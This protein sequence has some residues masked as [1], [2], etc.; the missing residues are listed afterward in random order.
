MPG[1]DL[2]R[3]RCD[4]DVTVNR[5]AGQV[6]VDLA[7][8]EHVTCTYT[9]RAAGITVIEDGIE[10][11]PQDFTFRHCPP[12]AGECREFALDDDANPTLSDR[13]VLTGLATGTHTVTQDPNLERGLRRLSCDGDHEADVG[14]RQVSVDLERHE[15]VTCTFTNSPP[16]PA[17]DDFAD[18]EAV[19]GDSG[20][21]IGKLYHA[22]I[23]PGEPLHAG[24][25]STASVW[26]RWTAP[27]T[28]GALFETCGSGDTLLAAYSGDTVAT[29]TPLDGNDDGCPGVEWGVRSSRIGIAAVAGQTYRIAVA[30]YGSEEGPINLDWRPV[31]HNDFFHLAQPLE[32]ESGRVEGN[33][34]GST[35]EGFEPRHSGNQVRH[36]IWYRFTAPRSG[37]VTFDTCDTP[38]YSSLRVYVGDD[39]TQLAEVGD[40]VVCGFEDTVTVGV[41]AGQVLSIVIDSPHVRGQF[42]TGDVVLQWSLAGGPP[43]PGSQPPAND[44]FA[45][46]RVLTGANGVLHGQ[47]NRFASAEPG[48]PAHATNPAARSVWY[49]WTAPAAGPVEIDTCGAG[50]LGDTV[51]AVYTGTSLATLDEVASNDDTSSCGTAS[52]VR[53]DAVAGTTY[54]VAVD[55]YRGAMGTFDLYWDPV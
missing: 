18:A 48:E 11:G 21:V 1:W 24:E 44:H 38:I 34:D 14:A 36:S 28:G 20:S 8:H 12:D 31:P 45:D 33:S 3:V 39:I 41:D 16:A 13:V 22:S 30:G 5:R 49:R 4:G 25:T 19:T 52:K 17:N 43:P 40:R 51:L 15:H 54:L 6:T 35:G 47:Y 50:N 23:E 53:F 55:G 2:T 42:P 26:Y 32:G 27:F 7:L 10:S 46:A 9:N 29:L 37:T